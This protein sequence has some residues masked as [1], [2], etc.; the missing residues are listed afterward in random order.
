MLSGRIPKEIEPMAAGTERL[1]KLEAF[2]SHGKY[3]ER[4]PVAYARSAK[5]LLEEKGVSLTYGEYGAVHQITR[6]MENDFG[7]WVRSTVYA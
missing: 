4:L 1:A 5:A 2:V 7:N 6:E 3:D